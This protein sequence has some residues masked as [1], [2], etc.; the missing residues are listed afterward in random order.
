MSQ[1]VLHSVC[2][3]NETIPPSLQYNVSQPMLYGNAV[4]IYFL[5]SAT[6]INIRRLSRGVKS[7]SRKTPFK[8]NSNADLALIFQMG[9]S[10]FV[11]RLW[12]ANYFAE[13]YV[14]SRVLTVSRD[15]IGYFCCIL[16]LNV[17]GLRPWIS[18]LSPEFLSLEVRVLRGYA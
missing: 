13:C 18:R 8:T 6:W 1:D 9:T 11:K 12:L 4:K 3:N 2:Q 14:T 17:L 7:K 16:R 15:K 10:S 5:H